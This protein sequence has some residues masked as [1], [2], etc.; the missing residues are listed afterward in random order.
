MDLKYESVRQ[1]CQMLFLLTKLYMSEPP[2]R[3]MPYPPPEGCVSPGSGGGWST[4]LW[5]M[6][7]RPPLR[8]VESAPPRRKN[9]RPSLSGSAGEGLAAQP[10]GAVGPEVNCVAEGG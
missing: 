6:Y 4:V 8:S 1:M 7:A 3:L 2:S 9:R 5:K 10:C